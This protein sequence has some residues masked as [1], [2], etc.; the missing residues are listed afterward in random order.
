MKGLRQDVRQL[1][2]QMADRIPVCR[3]ARVAMPVVCPCL[4]LT[5]RASPM[6]ERVRGRREGEALML[7]EGSFEADGMGAW[8]A[9]V[10]LTFRASPMMEQVRAPNLEMVTKMNTCRPLCMHPSTIRLWTCRCDEQHW[11]HV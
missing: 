4:S 6:I 10:S 3:V 11:D 7:M 2:G 9:C 1:S 8:P 5:F